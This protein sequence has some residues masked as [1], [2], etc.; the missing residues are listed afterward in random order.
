MSQVRNI[1]GFSVNE[2]KLLKSIGIDDEASLTHL[3]RL[4]A[5]VGDTIFS[6]GDLS[7]AFLILL[8]GQ[9]RVDLITKTDREVTLYRMHAAETCIITATTLL[10]SE[11]YFARGIAE[12]DIIALAMQ[13]VDFEQVMANSP[14]FTRFVLQDYARRISSLVGLV[15]RLTAKDVQADISAFLYGQVNADGNVYITQTDLARNI[16]TAREV[17]ARKLAN[18]EKQGIVR[19]ERGHIVILDKSKLM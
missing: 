13:Q 16:G 3:T 14:A 5:N 15:D 10:K 8:S 1:T 18:M 19:R 2:L 11:K 7:K 9:I 4:S 12:T 6:P 17:I